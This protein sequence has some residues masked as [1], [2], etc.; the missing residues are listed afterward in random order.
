MRPVRLYM[1]YRFSGPGWI[2]FQRA[3]GCDLG[4]GQGGDQLFI[5]QDVSFGVGQQ[6]QDLV[7]SLEHTGTHGAGLWGLFWI[8]F[9]AGFGG[10]ILSNFSIP[11]AE[12]WNWNAS[13]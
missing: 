7:L 12:G 13:I 9:L 4:I 2:C 8:K 6:L 10:R 11:M 3:G 1:D 5:V